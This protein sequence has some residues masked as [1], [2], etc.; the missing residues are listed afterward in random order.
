[1]GNDAALAVLSSR[2]QLLFAYFKQLFAQ[3]TNPPID[4]L[5]EELVMSLMSFVGRERNLLDETPEHCRQLKLPHPILTPEDMLRLRGSTHPDLA[6]ADIDMLFP[7]DGDGKALE[8]ALARLF[9]QAEKAI[10]GGATLLIL[11]DRNMNAGRAPIPSLLAIAGLHHHLIRRGL[12]TPA[13]IVVETGEA[14]EVMHFALLIGFGANAICP[15]AAFSTVRELAESEA[16]EAPLP[17]G[18]AVDN[19]IT[20]VKKGLL[21]TFSRMGISTL[22]S[23]LGSQIFE[24]VGLGKELVDNVLPQHGLAHRRHRA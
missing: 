24:A 11:T 5:R 18:E 2:P 10:R 7:A 4:P 21:K 17:P 22:R 15:Y 19:Y 23:F 9:V 12:R 13:S 20:A 16:L 8:T 6:S 3:V 14:R 1:M